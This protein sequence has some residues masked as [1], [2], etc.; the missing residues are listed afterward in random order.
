MA[1]ESLSPTA[2]WHHVTRTTYIRRAHSCAQQSRPLSARSACQQSRHAPQLAERPAVTF[3]FALPVLRQV[4]A[5]QGDPTQLM[6]RRAAAGLAAGSR[7]QGKQSCSTA[8]REAG[9]AALPWHVLQ[10]QHGPTKHRWSLRSLV[11][12]HWRIVDVGIRLDRRG[13]PVG[14]CQ[15]AVCLGAH[16]CALRSATHICS[17]V[18]WLELGLQRAVACPT[19]LH[20]VWEEQ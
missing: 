20:S 3:C 8:A 9:S 4:R 13:A 16:R 10:P 18:S 17:A 12:K 7:K 6:A 11:D 14:A 5:F 15:L 1:A 19:S 2:T